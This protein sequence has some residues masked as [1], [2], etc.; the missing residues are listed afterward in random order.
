VRALVSTV[1]RMAPFPRI[2]PRMFYLLWDAGL[3]G[4]LGLAYGAGRL[5][6]WFCRDCEYWVFV[7]SVLP[8]CVIFYLIVLQYI[9]LKPEDSK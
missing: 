6:A 9:N 3:C 1:W 7:V 5:T 2:T 8:V 4:L